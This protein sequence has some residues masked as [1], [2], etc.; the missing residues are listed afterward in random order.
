MHWVVLSIDLKEQGFLSRAGFS[1][2]FTT[3][4]PTPDTEWALQGT[5]FV[6]SKAQEKNNIS[7]M[8]KVEKS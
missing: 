8:V 6:L 2:P 1:F 3:Q 4:K 5:E 7:D